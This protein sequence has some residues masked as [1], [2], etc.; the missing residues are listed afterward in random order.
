[1]LRSPIPLPIRGGLHLRPVFAKACPRTVDWRAGICRAATD[2][3]V[4]L[5]ILI[6]VWQ[7]ALARAEVA[8]VF[9]AT[10]G[11]QIQEGVGE[12]LSPNLVTSVPGLSTLLRRL[13]DLSGELLR[14]D[15]GRGEPYRRST[16]SSCHQ[17]LLSPFKALPM[18]VVYEFAVSL[19]TGK[20]L[21]AVAEA[22]ML[23]LIPPSLR[24]CCYARGVGIAVWVSRVDAGGP[25]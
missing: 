20:R 11:I 12:L 8:K 2:D 25:R 5:T 3:A 13:V 15:L 6:D 17:A 4:R 10:A 7:D 21:A 9:P 23:R 14:V 16:G 22:K 19:P 24:S 1:M 18:G